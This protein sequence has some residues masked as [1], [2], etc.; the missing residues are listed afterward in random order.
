VCIKDLKSLG[1]FVPDNPFYSVQK[2][3]CLGSNQLINRIYHNRPIAK[4]GYNY[5]RLKGLIFDGSDTLIYIQT[6]I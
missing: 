4:V 3:T 2:P 5:R 6:V 1:D